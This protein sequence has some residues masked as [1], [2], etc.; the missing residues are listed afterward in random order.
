[1]QIRNPK[2]LAAG[3]LFM[4]FGLAAVVISASYAAGTASRM[5]PGYLPRAL[6]VLLLVFGTFLALRGLRPASD[7]SSRWNVRPLFTVLVAV[8]FFSL[9]AKWLGV[10]VATIALVFIASTASREFRWKESLVSGAIL[11]LAAVAVFVYALGVPLPVWPA[12]IGR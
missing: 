5:G 8:G 3:L 11:G 9:T 10:V 7:P 2:D 1:M 12:F 4:A 6:G